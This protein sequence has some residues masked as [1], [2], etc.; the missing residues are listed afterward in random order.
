MRKIQMI[1]DEYLSFG[2]NFE[3]VSTIYKDSLSSKNYA[4]ID[5][6]EIL[7]VWS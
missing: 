2:T 7:L 4:T 5:K 6:R 3:K 1:L